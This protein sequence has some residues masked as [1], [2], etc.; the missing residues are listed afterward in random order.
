MRRISRPLQ[1]V[2]F[3]SLLFGCAERPALPPG[4]PDRSADLDVLPGFRNPP[5]GYGEVPFWWWSGDTL[6][7]ERLIGQLRELH[8]KGV[9]GVQV[10]YSH[11]DTPGW[12]TDQDDPPVFSDAWW[13]VYA[14]ISEEC[15]RLN[16]GIGLSTYTLDW[17]RGAENLFY[18]LIYR[19][20]ELNAVEIQPGLRLRV[21]GGEA[22][23]A[24]LHTAPVNLSAN[25]W[26][27]TATHTVTPERIALWAYPVHGDTLRPGGM[28]LNGFIVADR[29]RWQAPPGEWEVW[30]FL[31]LRHPGSLNPL[32]TGS[33]DT[34]VNRFFQPFQDRAPGGSSGGLNYFFNDE[35]HIGLGKYAWNPDFPAEFRRRKGYDLMEVL[36]AMWRDTGT[37]TP[38]V[39]MDYADV[40]MA[41]MEER[42]FAPVYQWHADR[43]MI[44]G[45]DSESRGLDPAEFGDY[46]RATRWYSAPGHDTPGG[47]AD[48]MKG[49]VSASIANL[50]RRPRVWL[51]GYHSL[52]WGA[53]PGQL[54]YATRENYLYGCT[55]LNL[56]GLY[57]STYGSHWEWAPPCY[58]F[59]MPYWEHMDVFL[60][61]FERLSYLMSQGHTVCDVAVVYPVAPAE[62]GMD[63]QAARATAFE[64]GRKLL[65]SG[66]NF[67]FIDNESLARAVSEGDRLLVPEAGASY[68]ALVFPNMEAVRWPSIEKAAAF[69]SGGGLVYAVGALPTASDRAGRGDT[70]LAQLNRRAFAGDRHM[71]TAEETCAA[72]ARSFVPDVRGRDH[73]VR[74]LHRKAGFRD[75]Y[76]VM[77]APPGAVV[78][79][80]AKGRSNCGTRG[81]E[82]RRPWW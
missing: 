8:R 60:K 81:P 49:R 73:T 4:Y 33:G 68:R 48:P 66:I 43:G 34:V 11:L 12:L 62:A 31:A 28:D 78:E 52:G 82:I 55:L 40:R 41:L 36:P 27:G 53:T 37:N 23:S 5:P 18:R 15:A 19:H 25:S 17:P 46:F 1:F 75:V 9:S 29:I 30:E 14:R 13:Q 6:N 42:Y 63:G 35:L 10:N 69:A 44:F 64:L 22:V 20:P 74:A 7:A 58:H 39:R 67:E 76:L 2:F 50:Y 79:F 38:K 56:H 57:A 32:R 70:L 71:K 54:M 65:S 26:A 45:C 59:R 24:R 21:K 51:E 80:R 47:M 16:M 3:L 61:Y 72:I 77:D